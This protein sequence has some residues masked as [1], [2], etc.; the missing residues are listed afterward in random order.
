MR[1]WKWMIIGCLISLHPFAA[2]GQN[3]NMQTQLNKLLRSIIP[4]ET[5]AENVKNLLGEPVSK[6]PDFY[7]FNDFN[8]LVSYTTGLSCEKES[9][10]W[11]IPRDRVITFVV[12]LKAAFYQKD[13]TV[14]GIDLSKYEKDEDKSGH[15]PETIYSNSR[16]GIRIYII[17]DQ[18][19]RIALFPMK[20][21][22]HLICPQAK[23]KPVCAD[24]AGQDLSHFLVRVL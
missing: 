6:S 10:G 21:F 1:V 8:V 9:Y 17:G 13:L 16:E 22:L 14:F 18:V 19:T 12:I 7:K 15:V 20:K 3:K 4:T 2:Q 5:T 11:N 23:G 24:K